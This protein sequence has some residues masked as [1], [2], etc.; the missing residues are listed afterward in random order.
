MVYCYV[1]ESDRFDSQNA[2]RCGLSHAVFEQQFGFSGV[3]CRMSVPESSRLT[4]WGASAA[5]L[6][7]VSFFT[8]P[9][10]AWAGCDHSVSSRS[11]RLAN[12]HQLDELILNGSS[13]ALRQ[14]NNRSPQGLPGSPLHT[15]CSG[16]G[17]SNSPLPV[18]VS[19]VSTSP[20]GRDRWSTLG[21]ALSIDNTSIYARTVDEPSPA[22]AS[23]K[24]SVFHP[25]RV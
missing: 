5:M 16:P 24:S 13:S 12:L 25:P 21:N 4:K 17:C 7:A 14:A 9:E 15:P 20:D 3:G 8:A 22:P 19:T 11:D 10:T 6:L 2:F 1:V 23:E 18:P